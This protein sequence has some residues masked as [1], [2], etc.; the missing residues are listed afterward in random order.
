MSHFTVLVIGPDYEEQLAPFDEN[1]DVESHR[2]YADSDDLEWFEQIYTKENDG[3]KPK[4][5]EA[6]A[7]W[8]NEKWDDEEYHYEPE[9]GIYHMSTANP[10][11]YW[12][13]YVVGGRWRGF[14][15]L[16]TEALDEATVAI[17]GSTSAI[18][19]NEPI[20]DVD[21]TTKGAVDV[22]GMRDSRGSAAGEAWDAAYVVF[23]D[24][25]EPVPWEEILGNHRLKYGDDFDVEKARAEYQ[26][27][28]RVK[29]VHA[30]DAK[31]RKEDR[32]DD[33]ILGFSG[34]VETFSISRE[35]YVQ[36]ARNGAITTYA[37]IKD[38][39][40]N[41]PGKMGWW[42][43]SSDTEDDQIRFDREFNEMFDALADDTLL[44]LIDAH[45]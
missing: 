11:G 9:G 45:V 35:E 22:E 3:A 33:T 36:R 1:L 30:H 44:T 28:L 25:P 6:L 38:G 29:K 14:F 12:D 7:V 24:T 43:M 40:W 39:T 15:K 26:A 13:W 31:C 21:I 42:G 4:S 16:K 18:V 32:W 41:A 5:W 27:Q 10:E 34:G 2:K 20:Y 19:D 17:V 8:L 37:Y 23:G